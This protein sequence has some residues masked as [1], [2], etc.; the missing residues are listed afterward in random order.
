MLVNR[1][2]VFSQEGWHHFIGHFFHRGLMLLDFDEHRQ[3]RRIMQHAFARK[4]LHGYAQQ[5][6]PVITDGIGRWQPRSGFLVYPAIKQLTLDVV[7]K[8]FMGSTLGPEADSINRAFIDTGHDRAATPG[9]RPAGRSRTHRLTGLFSG[10]V[11]L[12]RPGPRRRSR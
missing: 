12:R 8:A 9:R 11:V 2:R 5:M 10:Q 1:D 7:T 6:A 3:H 4:R